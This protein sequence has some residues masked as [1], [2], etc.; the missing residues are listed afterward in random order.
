MLKIRSRTLGAN[1]GNSK[2]R[3]VPGSAAAVRAVWRNCCSLRWAADCLPRSTRPKN[4][5]NAARHRKA[6]WLELASKDAH[7]CG[8]DIPLCDP[9]GQGKSDPRA[10]LRGRTQD[11]GNA[12]LRKAVDADCPSFCVSSMPTREHGNEATPLGFTGAYLRAERRELRGARWS[13][14]DLD[15]AE[16]RIPAEAQ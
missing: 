9:D 12:A 11:A 5:R 15:K 16:W 3:L 8:L 13:E 2:N 1:G 6:R 14:C 10:D 4:T 7:C